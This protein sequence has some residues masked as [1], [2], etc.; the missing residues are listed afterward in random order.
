MKKLLCLLLSFTM[1]ISLNTMAFAEEE[2]K[3]KEKELDKK[4]VNSSWL[5]N[6]LQ[7]T[8]SDLEFKLADVPDSSVALNL[9]YARLQSSIIENGYGED[10][11]ITLPDSVS[12]SGNASDL[13][14]Q[15]FGNIDFSL[16]KVEIP[17]DFSVENILNNSKELVNKEY[18]NFVN[19]EEFK[20][21]YDN[22]STSKEN[23]EI[24]NSL[25][26]DNIKNMMSSVDISSLV[27]TVKDREEIKSNY[28]D[29]VNNNNMEYATF[30]NP[31]AS[32]MEETKDII[33]TL[34][35]KAFAENGSAVSVM[36]NAETLADLKNITNSAIG[37]EGWE[38]RLQNMFDI[39]NEN[40]NKPKE[41]TEL[42]DELVTYA[43][44]Q[45]GLGEAVELLE[46]LELDN[47][48]YTYERLEQDKVWLAKI[49]GCSGDK[50]GKNKIM[51]AE[52]RKDIM[53]GIKSEFN[54]V[55]VPTNNKTLEQIYVV[56]QSKIFNDIYF[57]SMY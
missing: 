13:F 35:N 49:L 16:E 40:L 14:E 52:G 25:S 37:N 55:Q 20:D 51:S 42:S 32:E 7:D 11:S 19:S 10:Y 31:Y 6:Q 21:I 44:S 22:V 48:N 33:D 30:E 12:I 57:S 50:N 24:K 18:S 15:E 56:Y 53:K 39:F 8:F 45:I 3:N 17:K 43:A 26:V 46:I 5:E 29:K 23:S 27:G 54:S 47:S 1:T 38:D 41:P 36:S 28:D 2:T 4:V 34:A 9:Q